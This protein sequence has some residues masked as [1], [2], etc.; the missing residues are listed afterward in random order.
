M[1]I[2]WFYKKRNSI[3]LKKFLRQP[4][5]G[6]NQFLNL[7]YNAVFTNHPIIQRCI[8][9]VVDVVPVRNTATTDVVECE[10]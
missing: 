10:L 1:R 7:P 5:V 4:K 2:K 6:H 8:T 9:S 3:I